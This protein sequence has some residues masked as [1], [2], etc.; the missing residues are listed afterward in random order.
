MT[1]SWDTGSCVSLC[2]LYHPPSGDNRFNLGETIGSWINSFCLIY[3]DSTGILIPYI[4][5]TTLVIPV[6]I[7]LCPMN[8]G[9]LQ[10]LFNVEYTSEYTAFPAFTAMFEYKYNW[11]VPVDLNETN[12]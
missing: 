8:P 7:L 3:W 6:P 2:W 11:L 1:D 10:K 12:D 9:N 4:Y 5:K